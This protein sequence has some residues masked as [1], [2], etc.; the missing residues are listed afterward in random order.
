MWYSQIPL[1]TEDTEGTLESVR[2]NGVSVLSLLS[3]LNKEKMQGIVFPRDIV[4]ANGVQCGKGPVYLQSLNDFFGKTV[5]LYFYIKLSSS[6]LQ[7][8]Y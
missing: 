1:I 4:V 7:S 8:E 6:Y 5:P 3:R 2:I